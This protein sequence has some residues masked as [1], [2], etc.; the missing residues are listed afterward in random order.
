MVRSDPSAD[1]ASAYSTSGPTARA[2]FAVS[3]QGVVVHAK[4][5]GR[6][7]DHAPFA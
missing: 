2:M 6:T 3:V 4:N 5:E 1:S 7:G